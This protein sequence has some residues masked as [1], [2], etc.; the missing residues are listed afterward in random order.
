MKVI[1]MTLIAM[2]VGCSTV[3][4]A[5]YDKLLT[6]KAEC[7][8]ALNE[9]NALSEMEVQAKEALG[10]SLKVFLDDFANFVAKKAGDDAEVKADEVA[11]LDG[12][13]IAMVRVWLRFPGTL[14]KYYMIFVEDESEGWKYVGFYQAGVT[15][16]G[17]DS[18]EKL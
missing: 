10:K 1:L 6:Q 12:F 7:E 3:P 11:F 5:D 14:A 13:R 17:G 4:K 15:Q 9:A 2:M 16:L 8:Q 18:N